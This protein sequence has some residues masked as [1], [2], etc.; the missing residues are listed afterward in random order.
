M[1]SVP[2]DDSEWHR[3]GTLPA[4]DEGEIVPD[5]APLNQK[6]LNLEAESQK[7]PPLV[8]RIREMV[9]DLCKEEVENR[10]SVAPHL[11][12]VEHLMNEGQDPR[13]HRRL[14]RVV[15]LHAK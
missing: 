15:T 1:T 10:S 5:I 2:S 11:P 9:R 13:R 12:Y 4:H 3:L 6:V 14:R 7:L 8:I